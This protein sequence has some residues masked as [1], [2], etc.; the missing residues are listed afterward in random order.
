MSAS[1]DISAIFVRNI[2]NFTRFE[3]YFVANRSAIQ[4]AD[5]PGKI[6]SKISKHAFSGGGDTLELH[7]EKGG[8]PDVDVAYQYLTFFMEDDDEL[9]RIHDSY[10]RGEM[11]TGELKELCTK[12]LQE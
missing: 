11:L 9:Q 4:M 6:K 5:S 10:K 2:L 3:S 8:N 7:R 12:F 1:I